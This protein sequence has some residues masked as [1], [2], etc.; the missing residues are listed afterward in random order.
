MT[1]PLW[2]SVMRMS[3]GLKEVAG[4]AN[5]PVIMQWVKDIAAPRWFDNDDKAWCAVGLNRNLMACQLPMARHA[6]PTK[7]DGYDLLRAKTFE[8]YG[9]ALTEP[10]FGCLLTFSRP[11]GD[12]VGIYLGEN[13]AQYYVLGANQGNA[14][15]Y[16]W[17]AKARLT[18]IRWPEGVPV[19]GGR[20]WLDLTG[21]VSTN[22]Q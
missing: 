5:N 9:I 8:T 20:V 14:V 1:D 15:G 12:H 19:V 11:E 17:I 21:A 13:M 3:V 22:E 2:L 7:R 6:D 16:A 18:S 4:P 10:V